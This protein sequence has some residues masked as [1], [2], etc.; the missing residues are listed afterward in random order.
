MSQMRTLG[1]MMSWEIA[2]DAQS[3]LLALCFIQKQPIFKEKSRFL[4]IGKSFPNIGK[5]L[6]N[7]G[8]R[9]PLAS[10]T[11]KNIIQPPLSEQGL[12]V[13]QPGE[14]KPEPAFQNLS[15]IDWK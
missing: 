5:S 7:I 1:Q 9:L 8:K 15:F 4:N 11:S 10:D 14:F 12:K 2:M 13:R 3:S 6:R